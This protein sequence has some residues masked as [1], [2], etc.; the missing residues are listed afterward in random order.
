MKAMA[1][2]DSF[3]ELVF[4]LEA[5]EAGSMFNGL[6]P[7]VSLDYDVIQAITYV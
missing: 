4:Y 7:D 3:S 1:A 6:L 2:A 5:C